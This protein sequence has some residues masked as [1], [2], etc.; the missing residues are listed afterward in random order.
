MNAAQMASTQY[1]LINFNI[2][3]PIDLIG[4]CRHAGSRQYLSNLGTLGAERPVGAEQ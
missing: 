1:D 3:Y 2:A 4:L